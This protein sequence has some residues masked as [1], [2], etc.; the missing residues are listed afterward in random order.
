MHLWDF[1]NPLRASK[2]N[3]RLELLV[4]TQM[5]ERLARASIYSLL[6]FNDDVSA[7]VEAST[8]KNA[9]DAILESWGGW[10]EV[11]RVLDTMYP[12]HDPKCGSHLGRDGARYTKTE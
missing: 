9:R 3:R 8:V 1:V 6:H 11:E 4:R 5:E 7:E 10:S 2:L 12:V